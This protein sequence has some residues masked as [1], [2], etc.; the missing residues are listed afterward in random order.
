M[1]LTTG[2]P[3]LIDVFEPISDIVPLLKQSISVEVDNLN[4]RGF[5]DYFLNAFDLHTIQFERK[6]NGELLGD[7]D[8]VENQ[9]KK[10]Y[11]M[12]DESYLIIEGFII[13]SPKGCIALKPSKNLKFFIAEREYRVNYAGLVA[14]KYQ[15]DKAGITVVETPHL[16]G[17]ASLLVAIYKSAQES[18]HSTLRRY[19]K[20][21]IYIPGE[22]PY[23]KSLMGIVG[24][25]LG[26]KRATALIDAFGTMWRVLLAEEE[27]LCQV[28]GI[29]RG[30]ARSLL[31]AVGRQ[32]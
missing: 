27:E 28:E 9:L 23:I 31:K 20:E 17:T 21:K 1:L 18:E 13:P 8:G 3:L 30:V 22:N 15:L 5:A 14:W 16:A 29:G 4:S 2:L 6:Q 25:N 11:S 12:A 24:A 10:Q 19:I 7:M 26:E 32:F